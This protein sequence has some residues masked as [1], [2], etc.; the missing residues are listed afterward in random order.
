MA[1]V[2]RP[3]SKSKMSYED[4]DTLVDPE[5]V[6]IVISKRLQRTP[7]FTMAIYKTFERNGVTE[8]SSFVTSRQ[9]PAVKRLLD[10]AVARIAELE[11]AE[12]KK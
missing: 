6:V 5:G 12:S 9:V 8:K 3:Q 11:A 2:S 10:I 7:L 1:A 4:V